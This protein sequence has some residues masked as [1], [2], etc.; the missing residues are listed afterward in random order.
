MNTSSVQEV[1]ALVKSSAPVVIITHHNPDG[2][3]VGSALG[4]YHLLKPL[5]ANTR[6]L[7]PN[8]VPAFL[9]WMPGFSD[10]VVASQH[11]DLAADMLAN[12]A[13]I[14]C[15]DFNGPGRVEQL[16]THLEKSTATKVVIDHHP[17]PE[18]F[19]RYLFS[20]TTASSTCEL[21]LDFAD[22]AGLQENLNRNM[23]ACLYTGIMTDTGSFKFHSCTAKTHLITARLLSTGIDK[24]RIHQEVL[25]TNSL[26]RLQMLGSCLMH[27]LQVYPDIRTATMQLSLQQQKEF[28]SAKGDT[29]GFVNYCLSVKGV[30]LAALFIENTDHIKI[31]F[32][33]K[34]KVDVNQIARTYFN[35]GGH[36]NAAG[37]KSYESLAATHQRFVETMK[38]HANEIL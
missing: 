19:P 1:L 33:S 11:P 38:Q 14:F 8:E 12:A 6:V 7:V 35:G 20:D 16:R 2:D 31:S 22:A 21:V 10:I 24:T 29:E 18:P 15:L 27:S 4:M 17:L 5:Q 30:E 37:G 36:V 28:Q 34:N 23:A 13:V 3:A 32:R 9:H 26:S 25:D